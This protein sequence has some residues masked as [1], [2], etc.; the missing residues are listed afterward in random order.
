MTCS[1]ADLL[2]ANVSDQKASA[3]SSGHNQP[4]S[5][6]SAAASEGKASPPLSAPQSGRNQLASAKEPTALNLAAEAQRPLLAASTASQNHQPLAVATS[7]ATAASAAPSG[8]Y[9]AAMSSS[10]D[11]QHSQQSAAAAST[12]SAQSPA[13]PS[14]ES[15]EDGHLQAPA[16]G[17][18]L[19]PAAAAQQ[20]AGIVSNASQMVSVNANE[21]ASSLKVEPHGMQTLTLTGEAH[22]EGQLPDMQQIKHAASRRQAAS[23]LDPGQSDHE[24]FDILKQVLHLAELAIQSHAAGPAAHRRFCREDA[25]LDHKEGPQQ[26]GNFDLLMYNISYKL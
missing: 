20:A 19:R 11:V 17:L 14:P 2:G 4:A 5:A 15:V 18:Q 1:D 16:A 25:I 6:A 8:K 21:A 12:A 13:E 24:L 22:D 26:V 7:A 23:S 3:S 10:Q 9:P